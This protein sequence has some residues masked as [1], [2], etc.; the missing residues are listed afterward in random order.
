MS[1]DIYA[2]ISDQELLEKFNRDHDN[3]WLG[4]LLQRYTLLLL[5]VCMKYLKDEE[6]AKD[7]VQQVFLKAITEL[8]KYQV[9]Y[10]K[11]WLYTIARNHCLMQL[12]DKTH[13]VSVSDE[14]NIAEE[15]NTEWTAAEKEH[16]LNLMEI[17]IKELNAPQQT[18][19]TLFYLQKKSYQEIVE[20]TGFT[21]L[22]VKSYIQN[23]KRN[24][25]LLVS[26]K[27]KQN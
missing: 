17:S 22:Q 15:T 9:D 24:L 26:E 7:A 14:M 23:G 11:S 18:C 25:K 10:I 8:H 13:V 27:M 4:I 12:R 3:V 1:K 21:L 19:V 2:H 6:S 20:Q 16:T 5:G